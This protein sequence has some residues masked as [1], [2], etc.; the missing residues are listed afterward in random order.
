MIFIRL[1]RKYFLNYDIKKMYLLQ[2]NL[3][4]IKKLIQVRYKGNYD[5]VILRK[6]LLDNK[7]NICVFC[8]NNYPYNILESAHL[9]PR[10]LL[11]NSERL[12]T[13]L[14]ELMC[15]SC[16]K[17]YDKGLHSINLDGKIIVSSQLDNY[18]NLNKINNNNFKNIN[19][20]N[21]GY[22]NYHYK[23]IFVK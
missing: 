18:S 14:V 6:Y 5:R 22:I 13:N 20:K 19:L 3:T 8:Q 17:L 15:P 7:E 2:R 16:H 1:Y 10:K 4:I 12:D 21:Q 11:N 9:I 23:N